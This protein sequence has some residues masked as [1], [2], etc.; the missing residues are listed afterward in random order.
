MG[1]PEGVK[2]YK[3]W[4]LET[5]M[6]KCILSRD[7][8]FNEVVMGN[9]VGKQ[10]GANF[11]TQTSSSSGSNKVQFEVET[12]DVIQQEI[13]I[14]S[15]G[16]DR[17]NQEAGTRNEQSD[18]RKYNLTR[19]KERRSVKAPIRYGYAGIMAYA[20]SVAEEMETRFPITAFEVA[21]SFFFLLA[22]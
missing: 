8:V 20:F 4:C 1:Y 12:Q 22:N 6:R 19:D 13:K 11:E 3:L 10:E 18:M 5:G 15:N 2:A 21:Y 9:L 17:Y 14:D 7:V 16:Y